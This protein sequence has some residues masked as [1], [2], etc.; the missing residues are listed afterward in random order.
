MRIR[1]SSD[2]SERQQRGP[3]RISRVAAVAWVAAGVAVSMLAGCGSAPSAEEAYKLQLAESIVAS[4]SANQSR[5]TSVPSATAE[6]E[7][8]TRA[9]AICAPVL[10]YNASH[11]NPYPS[12]DYNNPDVPTL[13]LEGAF[14]S[15]S[16]FNAALAQ[17]IALNPPTQNPATW[18]TLIANASA[19]REQSLAQ[20][21]AAIAGDKAAFTS[22]IGPIQR[23]AMTLTVD[24]HQAGFA[25]TA[26]CLL[27]F[28]GG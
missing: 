26:P 17:L 4:Y 16:P 23:L 22:T 19:L 8:L 2:A 9:N 28:G 21:A 13:K 6:A 12:F 10:T 24:A 27:L 7:F 14:F 18:Q 1:R 20:N 11:P 25:A 15:A 5:A 3:W